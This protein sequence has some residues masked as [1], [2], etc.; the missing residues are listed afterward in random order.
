MTTAERCRAR[1]AEYEAN[2]SRLVER[3]RAAGR[4][5]DAYAL[6]E[7]I[8]SVLFAMHTTAD[9]LDFE[10]ERREVAA[11]LEATNGAPWQ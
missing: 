5:E 11:M 1:A 9:A 3:A 6:D 8:D 2:T 7:S 4:T 10:D